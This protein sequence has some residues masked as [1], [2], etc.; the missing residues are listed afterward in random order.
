MEGVN[1]VEFFDTL[2]A[3]T[4]N[5]AGTVMGLIIGFSVAA[6][7]VVNV[8]KAGFLRFVPSW[9]ADPLMGTKGKIP[10]WVMGAACL[11]ISV[12]MAT[13]TMEAAGYPPKA[14]VLGTILAAALGP[15]WHDRR[16]KDRNGVNGS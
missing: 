5:D 13:Q 1:V 3:A 8:A 4:G 15:A 7:E 10:G 6:S 12:F 2:V 9:A 14:W 11:V 16:Q